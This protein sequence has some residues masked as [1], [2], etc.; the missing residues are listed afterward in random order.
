MKNNDDEG[1]DNVYVF[2]SSLL[3]KRGTGLI[4]F[5]LKMQ[6]CYR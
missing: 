4:H 6:I 3:K 5:V 1:Y 2:L